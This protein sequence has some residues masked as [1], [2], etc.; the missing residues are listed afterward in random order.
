MVL[1]DTRNAYEVAAGTFEGAIE[2]GLRKFTEFPDAL[3]SH[4]RDLEGK[5]GVSFCTGGICCER[6][7]LLMA[8][9]GVQTVYQLGGGILTIKYFETVGQKHYQGSCFVFDDRQAV[10]AG[11]APAAVNEQGVSLDREPQHD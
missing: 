7:A 2:W 4:K 8:E 5:T 1:L 6:A 9:E 11:L 3:R 10:D